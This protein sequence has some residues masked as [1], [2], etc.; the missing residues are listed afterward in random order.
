MKKILLTGGSGFLGQSIIPRLQTDFNISTIGLGNTD[1]IKTNLSERIPVF[2]DTFDI[3][4]HAAGKAHSIPKNGDESEQFFKVNVD[5]TINLCKAL[6]KNPP[7]SFIFISSVAVYGIE[8]GNEIDESYPLKGKIPYAKS[9]IDAEKYLSEWC[10]SNNVTL[11]ILR[12]SLLAG[13]NPPGNLG[14]MIKGIKTGRYLRIGDGSARKSVLMAEDI[15]V[16]IP[17]II[18]K[19]GIFNVCDDHH[20]SFHELEQ[21]IVNQLN[22]KSPKSIP[23]WMARNIARVGDLLGQN[24]PIN[25]SK[26]DKITKSLTFSNKKAKLELNWEP[27]DVLKNFKIE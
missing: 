11:G 24:A 9:K 8:T 13:K 23:L 26:L 4:V 22:K 12:P 10:N 19:G 20:P 6:E 7:Q 2:N 3:V 5:G 21:L 16:L 17:K 18:E 15:A 1:D 25:T 27:M 14:A